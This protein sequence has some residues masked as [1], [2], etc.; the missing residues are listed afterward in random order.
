MGKNTAGFGAGEVDLG[1]EKTNYVTK[2]GYFLGQE[3]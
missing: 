3:N 1:G 2:H